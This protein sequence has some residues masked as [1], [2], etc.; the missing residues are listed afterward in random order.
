LPSLST[1]LTPAKALIFRITHRENLGWILCNGLHCENGKRD[2]NF[3][4]IGN[5]DLIDKRR[6]RRVPISPG[7]TLA[8]YVPFY[9]TPCSPMLLNIHTGR[10]GV[11]P[12]KNEEIAV[13]VSSLS[14]LKQN[15]VEYVFTD[16]HAY[17]AAADFFDDDSRLTEAVDFG[18]LQRRD[19]ARD[20]EHP[21]KFDRYQ[22]EALAYQF[23]PVS[24][25]L[26]IGCYTSHVRDSVD[27]LCS[28]LGV[29]VKVLHRPEWYFS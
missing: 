24:A 25:F 7:G 9:F 15:G 18:P 23:V 2:P 22:A 10:G 29:S 6:S 3:V 28:K 11:Q 12:R 21:E 17:L 13:I 4:S 8:D 26:G 5:P 27:Q 20:P 16:R 14:S 19:F 1:T